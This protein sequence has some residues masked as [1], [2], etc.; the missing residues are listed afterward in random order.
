M[1]AAAVATIYVRECE[2]ERVSLME[3]R[4]DPSCGHEHILSRT[5]KEAVRECW[6]TW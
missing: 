6:K 5:K 1:V 2:I 3:L 4:I